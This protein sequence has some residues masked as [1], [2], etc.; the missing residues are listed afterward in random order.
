MSVFLGEIVGEPRET[1]ERGGKKKTKPRQE[2]QSA[3]RE[4]L[5]SP[6]SAFSPCSCGCDLLHVLALH[7]V[8]RLNHVH[9]SCAV[10][11]CASASANV[12]TNRGSVFPSLCLSPLILSSIVLLARDLRPWWVCQA[13]FLIRPPLHVPTL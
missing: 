8:I 1:A 7:S 3:R 6:L 4:M 2:S 13:P 10:C 5:P 11:V 12:N 9:Y